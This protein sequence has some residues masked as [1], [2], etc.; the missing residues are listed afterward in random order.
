[1]DFSYRLQ[2]AFGGDGKFVHFTGSKV[3]WSVFFKGKDN[4]MILTVPPVCTTVLEGCTEL[5]NSQFNQ[6]LKDAG[7]DQAA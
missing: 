7:V 5:T 3:Y 4:Q 2:D 1:M 6:I